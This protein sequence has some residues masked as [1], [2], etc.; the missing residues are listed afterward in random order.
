VIERLR[1]LLDRP[2]DRH[3]R[4][5]VLAVAAAVTVGFAS[6][7]AISGGPGSGRQPGPTAP[8]PRPAASRPPVRDHPRRRPHPRQ[9]PQDRRGS[10]AARRA[11][12]ELASH[13]A[14]QHV[15]WRGEGVAIRL[16]G[17]RGVRAVL[18]VRAATIPAARRGWRAFLHRYRD[19]GRAYLPRFETKGRRG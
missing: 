9:D 2:L 12:R 3:S 4:L 7:V 18:A 1:I 16:V 6:L 11:G 17:A 10:V 15:P 14:L 8:A 5:A 13:R 19:A